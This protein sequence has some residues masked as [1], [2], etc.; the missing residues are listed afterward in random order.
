M[1]DGKKKQMKCKLWNKNL[2]REVNGIETD[3]QLIG[4]QLKGK[5]CKI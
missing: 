5:G 2:I 3:W 4:E 1:D